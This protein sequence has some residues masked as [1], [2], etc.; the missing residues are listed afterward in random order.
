M[1]NYQSPASTAAGTVVSARGAMHA[2][3][4]NEASGADLKLLGPV[5]GWTGQSSWEG[6]EIAVPR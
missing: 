3:A 4:A 1:S 2:L 5:A 6:T